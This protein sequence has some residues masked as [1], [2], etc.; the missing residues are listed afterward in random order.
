MPSFVSSHLKNK[1]LGVALLFT[2]SVSEVR[3]T[4]KWHQITYLLS[5]S[6]NLRGVR[7]LGGLWVSVFIWQPRQV[8]VLPSCDLATQATNRGAL[9]WP[10]N[11]GNQSRRPAVTWQ[12]ASP[13]ALSCCQPGNPCN[14]FRSRCRMIIS[15]QPAVSS[16]ISSCLWRA[17][18]CSLLQKNLDL[19]GS[20]FKTEMACLKS[21]TPVAVITPVLLLFSFFRAKNLRE[22]RT[23]L[24]NTIWHILYHYGILLTRYR[25]SLSRLMRSLG[26]ISLFFLTFSIATS[27][28][29]WHY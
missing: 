5:T 4:K 13:I 15:Q 24:M 29:M 2:H 20:F 17:G 21:L 14:F 1:P 12:P 10:G 23:V 26:F 22:A 28:F 27:L 18:E 25:A 9:L 7:F 11:L 3:V 16:L 6:Q 19:S 8:I